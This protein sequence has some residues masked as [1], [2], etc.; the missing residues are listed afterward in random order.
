MKNS[1]EELRRSEYDDRD[2]DQ[3]FEGQKRYIQKLLADFGLAVETVEND[4]GS[5]SFYF[6]DPDE[7]GPDDTEQ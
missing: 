2:E 4:D 6:S 3:D 5:V 1:G 7:P